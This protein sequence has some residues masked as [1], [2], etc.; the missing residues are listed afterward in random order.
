MRLSRDVEGL[1]S[2]DHRLIDGCL[3]GLDD[4]VLLPALQ[5]VGGGIDDRFDDLG[6]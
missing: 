5:R 3:A 6:L 2:N 1:I 4:E